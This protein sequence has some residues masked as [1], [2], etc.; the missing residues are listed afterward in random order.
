MRRGG[1]SVVLRSE[2][3]PPIVRRLGIYQGILSGVS[4]GGGTGERC[5]KEKLKLKY[6]LNCLKTDESNI[7]KTYA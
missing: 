4:G 3:A 2:E 7:S 6:L 5:S 1:E